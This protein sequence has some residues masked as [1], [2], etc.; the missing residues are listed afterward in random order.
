MGASQVLASTEFCSMLVQMAR[1]SRTAALRIWRI[2]EESA[3]VAV[4]IR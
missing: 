2:A 1:D 3:I 4:R